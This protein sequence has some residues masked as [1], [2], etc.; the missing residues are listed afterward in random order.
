MGNSRTEGQGLV[1]DPRT[2]VDRHGDPLYR[3]A[4]VRVRDESLAEDLVQETFLAAL[5]GRDKFSGLSDERTWLISI[6][7]RKI[8][9][10][11]RRTSKEPIA[12]LEIDQLTEESDFRRTADR[13]GTWKTG[14]HPTEW[15]PDPHNSLE[16]AEFWRYL[17]DCLRG[18][19]ETL[20]RTFVLREME[21]M[22]P[23]KVCNVLGISATNLR[24]M[25]YRARKSLRRCL[26]IHWLEVRKK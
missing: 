19:P 7:K 22:P 20:S 4:L 14:R 17:Q 10:H 15:A 26:E 3:F 5:L 2:W 9:D 21:E 1:S 16:I 6:L 8:V 12:D 25:M 24:V 11:F 13:S 23:E 18:L